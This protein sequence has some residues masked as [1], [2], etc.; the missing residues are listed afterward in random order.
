MVKWQGTTALTTPGEGR[1]GDTALPPDRV[2]GNGGDSEGCGEPGSGLGEWRAKNTNPQPEDETPPLGEASTERNAA[3]EKSHWEG[4]RRDSLKLKRDFF[5]Q[6]LAS[7]PGDL[8]SGRMEPGTADHALTGLVRGSVPLGRKIRGK[9]EVRGGRLHMW[10]VV[11]EALGLKVVRMVWK[12][13]SIGMMFAEFG[14]GGRVT[15]LK[16]RA[17]R[18][19]SPVDVVLAD[20]GECQGWKR[21]AI[22][23]SGGSPTSSIARRGVRSLHPRVGVGKQR[24]YSTRIQEAR[25]TR[26]GN[27]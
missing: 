17:Y 20:E 24:A 12:E 3:G 6:P 7:R 9:C 18:R 16:S 23:G 27:W 2:G 11:A 25:L 4:N 14:V 21:R 19:V 10:P 5:P 13:V 1:G 26:C 8:F 22:G 15:R